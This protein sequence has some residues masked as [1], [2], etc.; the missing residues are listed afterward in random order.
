MKTGW[1]TDSWGA[2]FTNGEM[3]STCQSWVDPTGSLVLDAVGSTG[4][5]KEAPQHGPANTFGERV[6]AMLLHAPDR[7]IVFGSVNDQYQINQGLSTRASVQEA[8]TAAL[9]ALRA[10]V[11]DV[12]AVVCP[13]TEGGPYGPSGMAETLAAIRAACAATGARFVDGTGWITGTGHVGGATGDG[14]ADVYVQSD[15]AHP[16]LPPAVGYRYIGTRIGW[17]LSP[18]STGLQGGW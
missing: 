14:N 15:L 18:P 9:G 6:P 12:I 4:Y 8:A 3:V 16:A 7:V 1:I 10:Q 2:E 17:A 13:T 11:P 5:T